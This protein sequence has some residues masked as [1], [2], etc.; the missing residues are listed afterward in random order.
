[1]AQVELILLT[2][3]GTNLKARGV[4]V[5]QLLGNYA[6]AVLEETMVEEFLQS[7]NILYAELP[8]LVYTSVELGR[9]SSCISNRPTATNIPSNLSG[10]GVLVGIVDSGIDYAH[11]DFR[12]E[13]GTTRIVAL[14]DQSSSFGMSPEGYTLGTLFSKEQIDA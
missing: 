8:V 10:K 12:N 3:E 7:P 11:P 2:K 1:M 6:I 4:Q 9:A 5:T 14:W 13:D